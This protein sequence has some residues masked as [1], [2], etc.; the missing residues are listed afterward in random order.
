VNSFELFAALPRLLMMTEQPVR[1]FKIRRD[2]D[3]LFST[4]GSY[5]TFTKRGKIWH[6]LGHVKAAITLAAQRHEYFLQS[7]AQRGKPPEP[8]RYD[9]CSVVELVM[10]TTNVVPLAD[11]GQLKKK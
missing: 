4:G 2:K 1:M 7:L 9:G 8:F 11:V 10:Q 3:G 5:P 6:Q